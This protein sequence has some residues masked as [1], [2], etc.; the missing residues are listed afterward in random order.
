M[1]TEQEHTCRYACISLCWSRT[2]P[3]AR[4][5]KNLLVS[6]V[7]SPEILVHVKVSYLYKG[8]KN[9]N[10]LSVYIDYL[11]NLFFVIT[12]IVN[13]NAETRTMISVYFI[14]SFPFRIQSKTKP[15]LSLQASAICF[16]K[17]DNR[18]SN[19]W[20]VPWV[21]PVGKHLHHFHL[22]TASIMK[23]LQR[24]VKIFSGSVV[25]GWL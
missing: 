19:F 10:W 22:R 3:K 5:K 1:P 17:S 14:Y 9:K 12:Y 11:K 4:Y 21:S 18:P 15:I 16:L 20:Q 24:D 13:K 23:N 6:R 7:I 8:N 2:Q 25:I